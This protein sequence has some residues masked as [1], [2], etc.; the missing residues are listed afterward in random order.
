MNEV[1]QAAD[2]L[3][4]AVSSLRIPFGL[5]R[6]FRI[7]PGRIFDNRFL[8]SISRGALGAEADRRLLELV[9]RIDLPSEFVSSADRL[10]R[11]SRFVHF[12]FEQEDQSASFKLYFER[13]APLRPTAPVL[14]YEAF[15][16]DIGNPA[17][18]TVSRYVWNPLSPAQL[19]ARIH[20]MHTTD[21]ELAR[22]AVSI[23][24]RAFQ[25]LG[26][27]DLRLLE[28]T[29]EGTARQSW[30][31]NLYAANVRIVDLEQMVR[32]LSRHFAIDEA[33]VAGICEP[34]RTSLVG[35]IAGGVHRDGNE[36]FTVYHGVERRQ[37]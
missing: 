22:L 13:P 32:A 8:L 31:V 3:L 21:S 27:G 28:V 20:S 24:D 30:D 14:L 29:D 18:R 17:R 33:L 26:Q 25:T 5:E 36:F 35:H 6:S 1:L 4:D 15:K 34:I 37:G 12:G 9:T 2:L 11:G 16:W 19:S 10:I 23:L 7:G